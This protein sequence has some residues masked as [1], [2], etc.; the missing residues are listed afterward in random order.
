MADKYQT[1]EI[2]TLRNEIQAYIEAGENER[3]D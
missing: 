3:H 1:S 2:E